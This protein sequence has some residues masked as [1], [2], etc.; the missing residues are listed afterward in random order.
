MKNEADAHGAPMRRTGSFAEAAANRRRLNAERAA[1]PKSPKQL[2]REHDIEVRRRWEL[3]R[4]ELGRRPSLLG[5]TYRRA[6]VELNTPW[7]A[8]RELL[9]FLRYRRRAPTRQEVISTL[10]Y[11]T[12]IWSPVVESE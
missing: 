5:P 9:F 12:D 11:P 2:R 3:K 4:R 6:G 8:A 7:S 10:D 1:E